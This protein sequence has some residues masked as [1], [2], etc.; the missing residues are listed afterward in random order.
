MSLKVRIV[1]FV[2][3]LLLSIFWMFLAYQADFMGMAKPFVGED[4]FYY[5]FRIL[6]I[7]KTK[8]NKRVVFAVLVLFFTIILAGLCFGTM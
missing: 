5:L 1:L 2:L 8:R 6:K 4:E 7:R 3:G